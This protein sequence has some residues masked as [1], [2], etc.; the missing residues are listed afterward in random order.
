RLVERVDLRAVA[1]LVHEARVGE[2]GLAVDEDLALAGA[3]HAGDEV[4]ERALARP[5]GPEQARDAGAQRGGH[6]VDADD[7]AVPA[8]DVAELDQRGGAHPLW[9]STGRR[10]ASMTRMATALQPPSVSST[11][12][13]PR[14]EEPST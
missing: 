6:A 10:R 2:D 14:G 11:L 7:L 9:T 12:A 1:D 4:H 13:G 3:E 8:R 5:V